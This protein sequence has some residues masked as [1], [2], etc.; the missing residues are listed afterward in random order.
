M[1]IGIFAK[2]PN[3]ISRKDR[4]FALYAYFNEIWGEMVNVAESR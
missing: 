1:V 2:I 3:N 4:E